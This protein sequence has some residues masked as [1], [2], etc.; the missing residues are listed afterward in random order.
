MASSLGSPQG[1]TMLYSNLLW[2][3]NLKLIG[4]LLN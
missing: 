4:G 1:R 3:S 2:A